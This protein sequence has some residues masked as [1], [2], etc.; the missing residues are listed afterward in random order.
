MK[1]GI[2][3]D[4]HGNHLALAAVLD[5]AENGGAERLLVTGDLVGYYFWPQKVMDMLRGWDKAVVRGN[6]EA[7]LKQARRDPEKLASIT[8]KYGSGLR[9]A[10]ETLDDAD[11]DWLE[12]LPH[13]LEVMLDGERALLCHGSP[14][15]VDRYIYPDAER[16]D[17]ERCA[18]GSYRWVVLGH[19]HHPMRHQVDQTIVLNPGS[20]GQ[21]RNKQPG[22]HWALL[23]TVTGT[24]KWYCEPYDIAWVIE[25][26]SKIEPRLPYL[27]SIL[28]R[29]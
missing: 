27:S 15:D 21:P 26:S 16:R 5:A 24:I 28:S 22:A 1:I 11:L 29:R 3:G 18:E 8:S 6:H 9:V 13:P 19:T 7:M 12:S 4:V 14:W 17:L 25:Q 23:D 20:V 2:L 10:L